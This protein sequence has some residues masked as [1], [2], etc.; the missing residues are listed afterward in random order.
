MCLG[1]GPK[2]TKDQKKKKKK[3][4]ATTD[5]H[6]TIFI[7]VDF[8]IIL[9]VLGSYLRMAHAASSP[10]LFYYAFHVKEI[11]FVKTTL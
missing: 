4:G 7:H 10:K 5:I 3:C 1:C 8:P 11:L 2:K 6:I 9:S